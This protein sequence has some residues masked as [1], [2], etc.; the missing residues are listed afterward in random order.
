MCTLR[1]F[2]IR[3]EQ[4]LNLTIT[5]ALLATLATPPLFTPTVISKDAA[6]FEYI[7]GDLSLSNPTREVIS[8]A[9]GAFGSGERVAC[10]LSLGCGHLGVIDVPTDPDL[11][12][13]NR[14]LE[15]MVMDGE[16][17]AQGIESQMG[18]LGI[19]HRY[20]VT[21]GLERSNS[22]TN[23]EPGEVLAHTG[24]YLADVAV[25]RQLD[26][27]AKLLEVR[28]GGASLEQLSNLFVISIDSCFDPYF[29]VLWW[30]KYTPSWLTSFDQD[31]CHAEG[32]MGVY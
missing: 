29:R 22:T 16:Q 2:N 9:H 13:W 21:R 27:C 19:H 18:H 7:G 10:I 5:E 12:G 20:S 25:S 11:T 15:K 26:L 24:V 14:L 6:T 30:R 23:P 17:T 32:A 8:E 28:D 31:I 1:N 4:A 3:Q